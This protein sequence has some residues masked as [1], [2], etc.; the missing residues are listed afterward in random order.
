MA[1]KILPFAFNS[2]QLPHSRALRQL[3]HL[4]GGSLAFFLAL[5]AEFASP[6]AIS[7]TMR[8]AYWL[9]RGSARYERADRSKS[10]T[11]TSLYLAPLRGP[12]ATVTFLNRFVQ[13]SP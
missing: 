9:K 2:I 3:Q 5:D 10:S 8:F 12:P 13:S 11:L 7:D 1:R 4:L 6:S